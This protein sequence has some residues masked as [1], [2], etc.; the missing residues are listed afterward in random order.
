MTDIALRN[1]AAPGDP[2]RFDIALDGPDLATDEGLQTAV[3]LSLFTDRRAEADDDIP[4]GSNDR[5]GWWADAWP[6]VEGDQWGSRQW[7]LYREKDLPSVL[8]RAQAYAEEALAWMLED[9]VARAVNVRAERV[10]R[11]MLGI[12]IEIEKPDGGRFAG[13][14]E[15][16]LE[17]VA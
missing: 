14:W 9:G 16:T 12:H 17:A 8:Q 11:A 3:T 7:L 4:D 13:V 5:R 2:P 15:Y 10:R 1:T 6:Q